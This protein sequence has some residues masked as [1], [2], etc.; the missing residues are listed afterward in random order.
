[1]PAK[2]WSQLHQA[3]NAP[4]TLEAL[5]K[6]SVDMDDLYMREGLAILQIL[7]LDKAPAASDDQW[8]PLLQKVACN[9][10]VSFAVSGFLLSTFTKKELH[11]EI[12]S[13]L[14]AHI[15]HLTPSTIW[16]LHHELF[17]K[18]LVQQMHRLKVT[19][20]IYDRFGNEFSSLI[21]LAAKLKSPQGLIDVFLKAIIRT[22]MPLSLPTLLEKHQVTLQHIQGPAELR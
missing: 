21:N 11:D 16:L 19:F 2:F 15:G 6:P 10:D 22:K 1:M 17:K 14:T 3:L 4:E 8:S 13:L 12:R 18:A 5:S 9:E 20:C 7:V